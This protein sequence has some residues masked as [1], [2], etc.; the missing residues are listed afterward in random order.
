M[1]SILGGSKDQNNKGWF[2]TESA[3]TTAYPT[4]QNGWWAIVGT[5]DSVWVW[6]TDSVAWVDTGDQA[7]GDVSGPASSTDNAIPRFNGTT[8]KIIQS[9]TAIIDD[10]GN[11]TIVGG[12]YGSENYYNT[13]NPIIT[14]GDLAFF[15]NTNLRT[16]A[17]NHAY[18]KNEVKPNGADA[19]DWFT[20]GTISYTAGF[21]GTDGKYKIS[22]N[23]TLG[24]NT[25]LEISQNSVLT[26]PL[27]PAFE[28]ILSATVPNVTGD[29]TSYTVIFD[30]EVYDQTGAY[31]PATG[32]F[33]AQESGCYL[34][35]FGVIPSN[36]NS[37]NNRVDLY[38]ET[39]SYS[40]GDTIYDPRN[41]I[42][43]TFA[44]TGQSAHIVKMN[45]GQ[46]ARVKLTAYGSATKNVGVY[47]SGI[48]W[49]TFSG[50]KLG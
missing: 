5:T 30:T 7:T 17:G 33:T 10:N 34:F 3:L 14:V 42:T 6:D 1:G 27:Q 41:I 13:N 11:L 24:T 9:S 25:A 37:S 39:T 50:F 45:T 32:I 31:N 16:G 35:T 43:S 2:A 4:G 47:T 46:T 22:A 20:D 49:S 44:K 26:L 38:L 19:Y 21:D 18:F 40:Y 28:A 48:G 29:G 12:F 8:G 15:H 23:A 36:I